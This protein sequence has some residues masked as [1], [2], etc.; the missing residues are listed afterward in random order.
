MA[1]AAPAYYM[2]SQGWLAAGDQQLISLYLWAVAFSSIACFA[3]LYFI[4]VRP[5]TGLVSLMG[6]LCGKVT[7]H[8]PLEARGGQMSV[9][10]EGL[11]C[12]ARQW[13]QSRLRLEE[14]TREEL[15][16][17]EKMAT[18]G[19]MAFSVAHDIKN[20]LA[21]ISGAIQVFS[22]DFPDGD[23]RGEIVK[24][25]L[26]EIARLDR[27]VKDLQCYAHPPEPNPMPTPVRYLMERAVR[28][29]D[30]NAKKSRVDV[31]I[32]D[33]SGDLEVYVDTEQMH[34]ALTYIMDFSLRAMPDGGT[35]SVCS[36]TGTGREK[37]EIAL[38]DTGPGL[39]GDGLEILF[40]PFRMSRMSSSGLSMAISRSLIERQGG[41]VEVQSSPGTGTE[42]RIVLPVYRKNA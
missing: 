5:M 7:A 3:V 30:E 26:V 10:K 41:S 27:I 42:F 9:L 37:V 34:Q 40:K 24:D 6:D 4:V 25:I 1:L 19:E 31:N 18:L 2:K 22:E 20:P 32:L 38:K 36:G 11:L 33:D 21:G 8:P 39:K 15:T 17:M 14:A 28:H 29:V 16:R 23:P 12:I 13:E 35:L